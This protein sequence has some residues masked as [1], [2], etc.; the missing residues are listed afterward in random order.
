[1]HNK[2]SCKRAFIFHYDG[3]TFEELCSNIQGSVFRQTLSLLANNHN[4]Y[5]VSQ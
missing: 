5:N 2:H 3:D 1:M 4:R